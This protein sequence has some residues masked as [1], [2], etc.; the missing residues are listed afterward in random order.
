MLHLA[1]IGPCEEPASAQAAG[2]MLHTDMMCAGACDDRIAQ[3]PH[4]SLDDYELFLQAI[5]SAGPRYVQTDSHSAGYMLIVCM[6]CVL[7]HE[8]P[9]RRC[10]C[11]YGQHWLS[12]LASRLHP[13]LKFL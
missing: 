9:T 8:I 11:R 2:H 4:M 1:A 6:L 12:G 10:L 5:C 7:Y 13:L 3:R